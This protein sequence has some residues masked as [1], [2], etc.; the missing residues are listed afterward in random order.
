[1]KTVDVDVEVLHMHVG[2]VLKV[3]RAH[4]VLD[5]AYNETGAVVSARIEPASGRD[6]VEDA[7][8]SASKGSAVCRLRTEESS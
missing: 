1:M 2:A 6:E 7:L 5:V 3:L 4:R 8:K